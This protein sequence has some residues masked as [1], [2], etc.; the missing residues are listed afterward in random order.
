MNVDSKARK[1][2]TMK[3]ERPEVVISKRCLDF[4]YLETLAHQWENEKMDNS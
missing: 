2:Y 4:Q 1:V 3:C